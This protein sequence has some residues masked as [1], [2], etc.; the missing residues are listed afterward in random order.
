MNKTITRGLSA[1]LLLSTAAVWPAQAEEVDEIIVSATGIPTPAAQIG[2]SVDVITAADLERQQIVYLQDALKLKGINVPQNGGPGTLSNV[3]LRGLPGKYSDLQVD[4]ISLFDP[5]SNQVLWG[6]VVTD[7]VGQIEVLRGSQ[8]VLYG[9]N[10]I[11]GVIS[12][13]TDIGGAPAS[14]LRVESGSFGTAD[15]TF[16]GKGESRSAAYGVAVG[17]LETDGI[18]AASERLGN[19]EKDGYENTRFNGRADFYLTDAL[20]LELAARHAEGEVENDAT[21]SRTDETGKYEAFERQA[22]RFGL[23]FAGEASS[24][25]IDSVTYESEAEEFV[26]SVRDSEKSSERDLIRYRGI[27]SLGSQHRLVAGAES[28]SEAFVESARNEIDV[29]S[30]YALVETAVSA[31]LTTTVALR[32][33]DHSTFGTQ[34][35]H[36][37][38][39]AYRM[40]Q[41]TTVRAAYGTGFR[42]P[43]LSELY[44]N[45]Y[46]NENLQPETSESWE[47]GFDRRTP[48]ARVSVTG[49][50]INVDDIIGY[51]P[52]TYVNRQVTGTSKVRGGE[53]NFDWQPASNL[54]LSSHAIYTD[55]R[56]PSGNNSGEMQREVRVP[57][58]QLAADA[59]YSVDD[60]LQ[61]GLGVRHVK[62]VIDV[63]QVLLD[64]YTLWSLRGAYRV[65]QAVQAYARIEN[66]ADEDY[67]TV[68]GYGT[69]GRA[70]YVGVTTRF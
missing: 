16:T 69:P 63:S 19:S 60:R 50:S 65:T 33:D 2:A 32:Q 38:T 37:L 53:I 8:G 11:A 30:L 28:L 31:N 54:T 56:K 12:Q 48:K 46:G 51:D 4:G 47:L 5:R 44:L 35:T 34:E 36:R 7:G 21:F 68:S 23:R 14:V 41:E 13:T 1:A 66:A 40:A 49:Y 22:A 62:D 58:V 10:T 55:S 29:T 26:N 45:V 3:F 18:S 25:Q 59:D 43:S 52:N 64:D 20:T 27:F 17:R 39:A 61:I 57:R 15:L 24:Y 42:A 67:E 6:D 70:A 9:S